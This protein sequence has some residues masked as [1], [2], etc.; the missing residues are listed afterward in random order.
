MPSIGSMFARASLGVLDISRPPPR[1][2]PESDTRRR[3]PDQG[4]QGLP[5]VF[6]IHGGNGPGENLLTQG[7]V[8]NGDEAGVATGVVSNMITGPDRHVLGS[9]KTMAGAAPSS[10]LTPQSGQAGHQSWRPFAQFRPQL[11]D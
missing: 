4:D 3:T 9:A 8:A 1:H 11:L 7:T 2:E 5:D 10:R 6:N